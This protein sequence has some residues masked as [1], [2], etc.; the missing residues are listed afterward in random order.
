MVS[1]IPVNE[2]DEF[3]LIS[4]GGVLIRQAVKDISRVGRNTLGV[5]VVKLDEGDRVVSLALIPRN[6]NTE[7]ENPK[8]AP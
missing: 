3:V 6:G 1:V 4:R 8:E 7:G 5:R 2:N